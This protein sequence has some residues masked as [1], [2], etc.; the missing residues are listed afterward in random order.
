MATRSPSGSPMRRLRTILGL[1]LTLSAVDSF[2]QPAPLGC[3]G[4]TAIPGAINA[5]V[6]PSP[7]GHLIACLIDYKDTDTHTY[8]GAYLVRNGMPRLLKTYVDAGP[9][10][11]VSWSPDS[12][13]FAVTWAAGSPGGLGSTDIFDANT[14]IWKALGLEAGRSL[15]IPYACN[16]NKGNR[17]ISMKWDKW[18]SSE[19]AVIEVS[20]DPIAAL[21]RK[22]GIMDPVRFRVRVPSGAVISREP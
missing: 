2:G 18:V 10:G 12:R 14:G 15:L 5:L 7:A 4:V 21:C 8:T 16:I 13:R 9:S 6:E 1:A 17:F 22:E 20:V 11:P 3:P 19:E